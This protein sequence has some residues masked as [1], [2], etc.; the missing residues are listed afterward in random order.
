[1]AA[2][3]EGGANVKVESCAEEE[4]EE[5]KVKVKNCVKCELHGESEEY[6]HGHKTSCPYRI[7][8]CEWC[9]EHDQV[10]S[11]QSRERRRRRE[12]RL[13]MKGTSCCRKP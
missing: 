9:Q 5:A 8:P 7:C 2:E 13:I 10:L 4:A 1:M 3:G 6:N 12:A 11:I